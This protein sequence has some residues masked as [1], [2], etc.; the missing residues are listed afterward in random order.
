MNL[1]R[2]YDGG[3]AAKNERLAVDRS[4]IERIAA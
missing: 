1:Q 3:I 4:P 2:G